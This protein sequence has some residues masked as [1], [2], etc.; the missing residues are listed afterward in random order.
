MR[1]YERAFVR[2]DVNH[3]ELSRDFSQSRELLAR[4]CA[5]GCA[6]RASEYDHFFVAR[7]CVEAV[8][9]LSLYLVRC[10]HSACRHRDGFPTFSDHVI[11]RCVVS[12]AEE[13]SAASLK[14]K[15]GRTL[16]AKPFRMILKFFCRSCDRSTNHGIISMEHS[17]P[18]HDFAKLQ[19][20]ACDH[21]AFS[22][23][24]DRRR[25]PSFTSQ[26]V[27]DVLAGA[28]KK[29]YAHVGFPGFSGAA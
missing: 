16:C 11:N 14:N 24:Y 22:V 12:H 20:L 2:R 28:A 5:V 18:N 7:H 29:T 26:R 9:S 19:C 15:Y 3:G 17:L 6:D 23:Q 21:G 13:I 1:A 27:D 4:E 8:V 25:T 10:A